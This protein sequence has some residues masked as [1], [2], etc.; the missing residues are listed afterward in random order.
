M[1]FRTLLAGAVM[2]LLATAAM[3]ADVTGKWVAQVPGRGG[4]T[5]DRTFNFKVAGT[6]LTGTVSG[7][8]GADTP[9]SDGKIDGDNI[10]FTTKAEFNGNAIVTKYTGT[11]SGSE[12]KF[13]TEREGGGGG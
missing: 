13:K 11:V 10:S 5:M 3:A 7:F 12:I 9:I 8:Q 4:Q 1:K 2:L 6:A